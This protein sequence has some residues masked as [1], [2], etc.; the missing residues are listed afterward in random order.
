[1]N[2]LQVF[3]FV[4][5][6]VCYSVLVVI[7]GHLFYFSY[8]ISIDLRSNSVL[9]ALHTILF[10]ALLVLSL[11]FR[12]LAFLEHPFLQ[13]NSY[14]AISLYILIEALSIP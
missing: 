12:F 4:V 7:L 2:Y 9:S 3:Y 5:S 10:W 8:F 14:F 6:S 11:K 13:F 1:M